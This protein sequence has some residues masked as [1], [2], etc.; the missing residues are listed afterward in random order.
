MMEQKVLKLIHHVTS[1]FDRAAVSL[2]SRDL[3][4]FGADKYTFGVSSLA[5]ISCTFYRVSSDNL[6]YT[7]ADLF[8]KV[9]LGMN[10]EGESQNLRLG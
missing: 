3:I 9:F 6:I 4:R 7:N 8:L 1:S 10:V 5:I 2:L